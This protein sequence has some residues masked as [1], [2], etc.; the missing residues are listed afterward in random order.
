[1]NTPHDDCNWERDKEYIKPQLEH[2]RDDVGA[3]FNEV[4]CIR[5]KDI[6]SIRVEIAGLKV[7]ASLWGGLAGLVPA[8]I[9]AIVL[10]LKLL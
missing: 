5:T 3:L 6:P 9:S 1:M 8:I 10:L 4:K 7:R 2:M